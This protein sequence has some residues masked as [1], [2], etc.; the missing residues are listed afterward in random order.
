MDIVGSRFRDDV[1]NPAG[2]AAELGSCSRGDYLKFLHCIERNIDR[3]A[4]AAELLAKE[5]VVV[6]AAIETDVVKDTALS[7]EGNLI[8]VRP[9]NDADSRS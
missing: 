7:G 1:D 6:V 2:G 9:L 3:G 4:L 5:T 8:A